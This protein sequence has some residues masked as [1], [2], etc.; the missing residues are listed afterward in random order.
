LFRG[1]EERDLPENGPGAHHV[2][3][4]TRSKTYVWSI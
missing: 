3:T 4:D 2:A 1:S